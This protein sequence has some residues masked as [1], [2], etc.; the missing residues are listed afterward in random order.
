MPHQVRLGDAVK[1]Q[2]RW[3]VAAS[4]SVTRPAGRGGQIELLEAQ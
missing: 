2:H 3:A 4:P 1:Q